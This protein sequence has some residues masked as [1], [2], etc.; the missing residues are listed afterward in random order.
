ME[1]QEA[2]SPSV[3]ERNITTDSNCY[4]KARARKQMTFT[5]V[6]QDATAVGTIMAWIN[7]NIETAPEVKLR[8]A[9]EEVLEMR[10]FPNRKRAD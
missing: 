6:E 10:K 8:E 1:Y 3:R 9:F 7:L 4:T 2:A 5:V